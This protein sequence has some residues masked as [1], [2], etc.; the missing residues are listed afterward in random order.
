MFSL[1]YYISKEHSRCEIWCNKHNQIQ[2]V[3]KIK[4]YTYICFILFNLY[5][6]HGQQTQ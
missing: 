6:T 4:M 3:F 5:Q 2:F 1:I